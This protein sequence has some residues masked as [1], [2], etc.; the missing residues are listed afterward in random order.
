MKYY[1]RDCNGEIVGNKNGY[2]TFKGANTQ[3]NNPKMKINRIL[4]ERFDNRENKESMLICT[5]NQDKP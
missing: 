3:V 1:L 4:W 2:K 5:I